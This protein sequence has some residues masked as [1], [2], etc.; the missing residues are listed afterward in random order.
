M[1]IRAGRGRDHV[2]EITG[3]LASQAV[4]DYHCYFI[5]NSLL[6]R[7]PVELVTKDRSDVIVEFLTVNETC[8]RVEN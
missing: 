7:K 8:C 1:L 6:D 4:E 2:A 5:V 3:R